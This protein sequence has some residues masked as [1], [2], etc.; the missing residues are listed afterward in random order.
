V[1]QQKRNFENPLRI[2]QVIPDFLNWAP[3]DS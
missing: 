1:I 3:S 2:D